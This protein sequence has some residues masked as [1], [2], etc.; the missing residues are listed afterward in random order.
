METLGERLKKL[1]KI[2]DLTQTEFASKIGSVQN[3]ITGYESGRRNPSAPVIS[4]ICKE[5]NVNEEWLRDG[6][7]EI[8]KAAPSTAL[9]AL[10]EEYSYSHRDY[11]I[12]EKFS[13]LSRKDRDVILNFIMEVAAGCYDVSEDTPA[14][15]EGP[16]ELDIDAAVEAYR[17]TLELQKKAAAESSASNGIG[18]TKGNEKGA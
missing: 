11:V 2:L 1:R 6:T 7:G 9:D 12:V 8:F 10:A 13:N 17:H 18:K 15:P 5:F 16:A 3:S 14:I 4:L